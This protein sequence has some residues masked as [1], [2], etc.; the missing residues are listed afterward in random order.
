MSSADLAVARLR[1]DEGFR[2]TPYR[3]TVGKLTIGYGLNLDAGITMGEA[4][5]LLLGR[6][7]SIERTLLA[8][9]WYSGLND[10]RRAAILNVAYNC[11]V[12]GLLAFKRMIAALTLQDFASAAH[13]LLDSDAARML[14][15]RYQALAKTL[16]EGA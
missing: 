16:R 2:A 10:A 3:D 9:R 14:P 4:A 1:V 15:A 11:G 12:E 8:S 5:G 6:V 13:E 7:E